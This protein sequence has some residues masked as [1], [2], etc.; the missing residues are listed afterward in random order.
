MKK[1]YLALAAAP[2][3]A[4]IATAAYA[5]SGSPTV[6]SAGGGVNT[7]QYHSYDG[8]ICTDCHTMHNSEDGADVMWVNIDG[9]VTG[10]PAHELLKRENWTD[11]CLSCHMQGQ[12]TASTA[13]LPDVSQENGQ[14]TAPIVMTL[15]GV[16]PAGISMPA[17]DFYYSNLDPKKGHNPAYTPSGTKGSFPATDLSVFMAVDPVLGAVPPGGN[18]DGDDEWSCH[19]CHGMHSRFSGSYTAWRQVSRS[20]NGIIHTGPVVSFGVETATGNKTQNAAYEP[21]KSNSRGDVQG[22]AYVNTRLDGNPVEGA[23]LWA[24]EADDNKNVYRGGFSSFCSTCHGDFHGEGTLESDLDANTNPDGSGRWIRHPTNILMD[25]TPASRKYGITTYT[26]TITNAQGNNPNP[27]GYDWRYP[28]IQPD[29]D[30]TVSSTAASMAT[31]ATALAESR[32]SCLT[33]HKAHATQYENMTRWD[34]TGH[35]FISVGEADI[36]G[37][38]SIGDNPA[39]GCGKCHQKGGTKAFVKAF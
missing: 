18:L 31:P 4:L 38:A 5:D 34:T 32:I 12:N 27:V 24:D 23:N 25:T 17:G 36:D 13:A 9:T 11:M 2:L 30:F 15:D 29:T 22:T 39:F 8:L 28:L 3:A 26:A 14:W 10:G 16:D 35:A 20:T 33:C 7:A 1:I 19:T 21:I 37:V 6:L